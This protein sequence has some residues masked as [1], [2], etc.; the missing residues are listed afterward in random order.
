LWLPGN[1]PIFH[2]LSLFFRDENGWNAFP[3]HDFL[4]CLHPVP[5]QGNP[6]TMPAQSFPCSFPSIPNWGCRHSVM[7]QMSLFNIK[8]SFFGPLRKAVLKR[9]TRGVALEHYEYIQQ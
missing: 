7:E 5:P 9:V 8:E 2:D 3:R 6:A 1:F 4:H